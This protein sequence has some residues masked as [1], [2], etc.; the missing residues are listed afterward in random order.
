LLSPNRARILGRI[1]AHRLHGTHD[2]TKTTKKARE[3]F[4]ARFEREA[5]PDS[6]LPEGER[7]RRARHLHKAHMARLSLLAVEARRRKRA[8]Q[9]EV[10]G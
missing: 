3:A 7:L 1:G 10:V 6:I 5:D 8:D 4:L 2:P 9:A